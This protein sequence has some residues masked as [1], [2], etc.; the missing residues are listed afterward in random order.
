[1]LE[2]L[3]QIVIYLRVKVIIYIAPQRNFMGGIAGIVGC[4]DN[5]EYRL[6][7]ML[8]S[9]EHWGCN[10]NGFWVSS[11]VNS[12]LGL[13]H[14]GGAVSEN[15]EDV[16]QPFVDE[17][18]SLVVAVDG[19]I[20]NYKAL[21]QEL[22]VH[23]LFNTDSSVEVVSKA[24]HRWGR[25]FL[26]R[27]EGGFAI[28]VYD[29]NKG[30]LFWA[31]DR[32]GLKPLYYA[33]QRGDLFFSS[34]IG[35]LFAGGV[36]RCVSPERWAGYMLYSSYGPAYST[37]WE[38]VHQLPAGFWLE[39]NGYSLRES[40]WY[41]LHEEVAELA[42]DY[43]ARQLADI[44][45]D[46]L[47]CCA[48]QSMSD[49]TS[50]GLRVGGRV[51]TQALHAIAMQGQ[52]VWKIQTF[53]SDVD[54]AGVGNLATPVWV[55]PA[56]AIDELERMHH[57]VEEPFDGTETLLRTALFRSMHRAGVQVVC[58]G[59]GL[60]VLWQDH[61]DETDLHYNYLQQHPLFSP[62]FVALA[63]RPNYMY[64]FVEE[65]DNMRYLDLYYERIPHILRFF[66]RSAA[67]VGIKVRAPFL[68]SRL[69]AL[70]FALPMVSRM[71]RKELFDNCMRVRYNKSLRRN[72]A[73]RVLPLWMSGGLKE[74]VGDA[75]SDLRK[76]AVRDWFDA[77]ELDGMW[78]RFCD[79]APLD[80]ALLWKCISLHRQLNDL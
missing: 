58:S 5:I 65:C 69:V 56:Q 21:R 9:Q 74:W 50:C 54:G 40:A 26:M 1:M 45:V 15:E 36:R 77:R 6:A 68:D 27:L 35:S 66:D 47:E 14:C 4:I 60:D 67:Q 32:F 75:L 78:V 53:T 49:V 2:F 59:I 17:D 37:F 55:T 13:T 31:R 19:E 46:R 71:P 73:C 8:R 39:Y 7:A 34:E 38:G 12:Q 29:R 79:G 20:Y 62:S 25:D 18:T 80:V 3:F 33:T 44:F 61:W 51:E 11:F 48:E 42:S 52:H 43:N 57:W 70:S 23:Y 30:V 10:N 24:Y 63:E 28:V 72:T 64:R 22:S 41:G 76:S 16:H